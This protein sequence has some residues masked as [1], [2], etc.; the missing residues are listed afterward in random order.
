MTF[1]TLALRCF[2]S[3]FVDKSRLFVDGRID[4]SVTLFSQP[5]NH[6]QAANV[7]FPI[8]RLSALKSLREE[9]NLRSY[10]LIIVYQQLVENA[11][12]YFSKRMAS[13][14]DAYD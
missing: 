13:T 12:S 10:R 11:L 8:T 1:D 9:A 3:S 7:R 6:R 2:W 4:L 5:L 14:P